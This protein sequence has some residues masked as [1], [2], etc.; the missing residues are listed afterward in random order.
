MYTVSPRRA[1]GGGDGAVQRGGGPAGGEDR[2]DWAEGGATVRQVTRGGQLL[3]RPPHPSLPGVR[4]C[5]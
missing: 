5:R 3:H 4:S 2:A 1:P